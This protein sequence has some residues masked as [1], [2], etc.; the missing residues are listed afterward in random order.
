MKIKFI[1]L[2]SLT[3]TTISCKKDKTP[4]QINTTQVQF[5]TIQPRSYYPVYPGSWWQ[6]VVND[7]TTT[8]YSVSSTY[9]PHSYMD[10]PNYMSTGSSSD[11]SDT[12]YVP[13]LN[14]NPIYGY[15]K[16]VHIDDPFG[17]YYTR[18]PILKE[19]VGFEF[20]RDWTDTRY[21]DFNEKVKV[22]D[23]YFNGQD[24]ILVLKGHWIYGPNI[25][26]ISYQK[27]AKNIGLTTEHIIDTVAN[28]TLY[29]KYLVNYFINN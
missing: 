11:Y 26:H 5:D 19:T 18:W 27:Y 25:S 13:F 20:D 1:L 17:N 2:L 15:E 24:S 3:I 8:H 21:G 6:Y 9:L 12:A 10:T 29:K 28:D 22:I 4:T 16:I 14:S 23:K 7:S